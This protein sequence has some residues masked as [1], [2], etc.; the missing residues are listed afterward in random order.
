[1][2]REQIAARAQRMLWGVVNSL[3]KVEDTLDC[4]VGLMPPSP[5][6]ML[7]YRVPYDVMLEVDGAMRCALEDDLRP[8]IARL[9]RAAVVTAEELVRAWEE[10][11]KRRVH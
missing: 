8:M 7:E 6:D 5:S 11:Q 4:L 3:Q 1:M 2:T 10:A 9:Q